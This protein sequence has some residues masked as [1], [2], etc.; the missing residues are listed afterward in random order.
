GEK[1]AGHRPD[2]HDQKKQIA[3]YKIA[4]RQAEVKL[5][6]DLPAT[7]LWAYDRR[8]PG[9]TVEG[10]GGERALVEWVNQL[11]EKHFLPIDHNLHG[12]EADKPEA[13]AVVHVH[14]GRTPSDSDGY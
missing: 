8:F 3:Y 6:R 13:R 4:M 11:P 10:R 9:P 1:S 12:A 5:H 7:R 2:P 14:G